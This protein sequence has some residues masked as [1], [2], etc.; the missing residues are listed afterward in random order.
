MQHLGS[1]KKGAIFLNPIQG[2]IKMISRCCKTEVYVTVDHYICELCLKPCNTIDPSLL[3]KDYYND[4]G[5]QT[6]VK[7]LI[8]TA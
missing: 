6:K 7:E 4:T 1:L 3:V 5:C 2:R 8:G